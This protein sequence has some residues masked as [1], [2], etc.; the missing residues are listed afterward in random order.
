MNKSE[1]KLFS[2]ATVANV[3]C[4]FDVL[5]LC[6]DTIGD[7]MVVRK[8]DEKGV[9]I[10]KIEGFKLPFETEL[11]V[12][13]VSALA[14]YQELEPDCGFEIEIHKGTSKSIGGQQLQKLKEH[15]LF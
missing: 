11:N 6:L 3:A 14:M 13:G 10:T 8:V 15:S 12:A 2:P 5:G 9:R 1:I 7:E 4:G